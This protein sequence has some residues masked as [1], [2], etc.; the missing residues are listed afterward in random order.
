MTNAAPRDAHITLPAQWTG[1]PRSD[2]RDVSLNPNESRQK[3]RRQGHH[4]TAGIG[5]DLMENARN[6]VWEIADWLVTDQQLSLR[7][8]LHP[9]QCGGRPKDQRDS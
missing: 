3:P 2:A 1:W 4:R 8:G 5:P 7:E 6:V 9:L